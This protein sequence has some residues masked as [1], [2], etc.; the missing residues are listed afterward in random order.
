VSIFRFTDGEVAIVTGGASGLGRALCELLAAEGVSVVSFQLPGQTV[1]TSWTVLECDV[2]DEVAVS[3][4]VREVMDRFGRL[5]MLANSAAL[6][7]LRVEAPLL[8]HS[9]ALFR[10]VVETNL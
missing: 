10:E 8:E 5:D 7:G 2:R 9:T 6:V 4:C 3:G 1:A